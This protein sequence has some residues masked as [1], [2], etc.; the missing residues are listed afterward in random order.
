[1]CLY[2]KKSSKSMLLHAISCLLTIFPATWTPK[3][4]AMLCIVLCVARKKHLK[5]KAKPWS[6]ECML[7]L[8]SVDLLTAMQHCRTTNKGG[9]EIRYLHMQ[10]TCPQWYMMKE[11]YGRVYAHMALSGRGSIACTSSE[12]PINAQN[13]TCWDVHLSILHGW[14]WPTTI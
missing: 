14:Y 11:I 12:H 8:I 7:K 13:S 3:K 10:N 1:M 6:N 9:K 5:N 2:V 4:M